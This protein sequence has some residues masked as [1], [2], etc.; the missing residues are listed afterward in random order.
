M[1]WVHAITYMSDKHTSEK[2]KR[3]GQVINGQ[4]VVEFIYVESND[5]HAVYAYKWIHQ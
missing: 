4:V 3:M 1:L 5:L 2:K